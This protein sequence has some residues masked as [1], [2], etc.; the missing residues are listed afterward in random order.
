MT[1]SVLSLA[2]L[3]LWYLPTSSQQN[4]KHGNDLRQRELPE[5]PST[6]GSRTGKRNFQCS[7]GMRTCPLPILLCLLQCLVSQAPSNPVVVV[8]EAAATVTGTSKNK[9]SERGNFVLCCSSQRVRQTLIVLF[10]FVSFCFTLCSFPLQAAQ[11]SDLKSPEHS[12]P[13]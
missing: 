2:F 9:N 10:C 4:Q 6:S 11:E 7:D 3:S 1:G 13:V 12:M 5:K 8:L